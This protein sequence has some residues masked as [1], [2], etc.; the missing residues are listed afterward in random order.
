MP[1]RASRNVERPPLATPRFTPKGLPPERVRFPEEIVVDRFIPTVRALL[2]EDLSKRGLTQSQVAERLGIS[3]SAVSKYELGKL[4]PD[5]RL[6]RDPRVRR[7]VARVA[8]GLASGEVG[9]VE[10]LAEFLA[11]ARELENR[12]PIC[13]IHEEEMPALRGLG[14]DLCLRASG[15]AVVAE[16]AAL[17]DVRAAVRVL[18]ASDA[19]A[20]FIPK[21]GANVALALA[22]ARDAS[23]VASV[24]GGLFVMKS[25]VK[26]PAPPEFGVS[27]HMAEIALAVARGDPERRAAM[28]VA[29]DARLLAAARA[30]GLAVREVP[31]AIERAPASLDPEIA[32]GA[33]VLTHGG[34]FGVEPQTYLLGASALAVAERAV[35][36]ATRAG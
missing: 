12:G 36:L 14:C 4:S 7:T 32:R 24:P 15:S 33:D 31:A 27:R 17:A 1:P 34:D 18:E 28:N 3:Q 21:V 8:P 11:L 20:A 29:T 16:Q 5:A 23:S 10:A 13:E 6:A 30:A 22:G 9:P 2:V 19:L 35:G 26:A 25:R